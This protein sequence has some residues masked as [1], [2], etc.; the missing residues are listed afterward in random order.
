MRIFR[1]SVW[2]LIISLMMTACGGG[3]EPI[4]E[5]KPLHEQTVLNI[6][7]RAPPDPE[8]NDFGTILN[9]LFDRFE[10][11]NPDID[12]QVNTVP[13][14]MYESQLTVR[15]AAEEGPDIYIYWPGG[16][17][18][19]QIRNGDIREIGQVWKDN[20]LTELFKPG[21]VAGSIHT[22]GKIY[23]LPI[24]Y[25]PNTFWY[26]KGIFEELGLEEPRTWAELKAVAESCQEAGYIPFAVGPYLTRWMP[27]FWF[28][29]LLLNT[30]GGDFRERLMWG[31]ESWE[32][33]EVHRVF[34]LWKELI[35][36]GYFNDNLDTADSKEAIGMVAKGEAAMM[37]QGPWAINEFKLYDLEAQ[38]DYDMFPFPVMD[39]SVAPAAEGATVSWCINP[40]TDAYEACERFLAFMAG[41]EAMEYLASERNTLSPRSDID[42][43]IYDEA[44]R[45]L[46]E[47]L[48]NV[49]NE[50]TLYMNFELATLPA[51][52][53]AGMDAFITFMKEPETYKEICA[54]LER[55]SR[56]TFD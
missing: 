17:V 51:M 31:K 48:S 3:T 42:F 4:S 47:E 14:S 22:D 16:R 43:E 11:E 44:T 32:S 9:V 52:Q 33:P 54:E 53:D 41:Y 25:K 38:V 28:D 23:S 8:K 2:L 21:V 45:G 19:S 55:I 35:D 49:V 40:A 18:E 10:A 6:M 12:L 37:L 20:D 34:E 26:N 50:S 13:S 56:E 39:Y 46:M 15:L 7:H 1:I 36:Q 29:Y 27:V 24:E 5:E 30:A